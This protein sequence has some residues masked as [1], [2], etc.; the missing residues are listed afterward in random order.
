MFSREKHFL[1][2]GRIGRVKLPSIGLA[3][4][5]DA[6]SAIV[7]RLAAGADTAVLRGKSGST[8]WE[9]SSC[10]TSRNRAKPGILHRCEKA[11]RLG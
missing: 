8:V 7:I 1:G 11:E 2:T 3:P 4:Q 6:E 9:S 5:N 10:L